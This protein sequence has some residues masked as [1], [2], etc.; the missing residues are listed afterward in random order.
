[1]NTEDLSEEQKRAIAEKKRKQLE[2][3]D[4]T[5]S[6]EEAERRKRAAHETETQS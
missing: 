1:M 5:V 6:P 4:F 2:S 3:E